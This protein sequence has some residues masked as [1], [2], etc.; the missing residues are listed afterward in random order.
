[1]KKKEKSQQ[2]SNKKQTRGKSSFISVKDVSKSYSL[3][4]IEVKALDKVSLTIKKGEIVSIVGPSGS[5]KTTLLNVIGALDYVDSGSITI[6]GKLLSEM[7]DK[8]WHKVEDVKALMF[9]RIRTNMWNIETVVED[10]VKYYTER[11]V[12]SVLTF[13][14]YYKDE[15]PE[16]Y[17]D[18]Y[19]FRKRT[20]NSYWVIRFDAWKHIM[21]YFES[22]PLVHSC[23]GPD[24][25]ACKNCGT[26]LREFHSTVERLNKEK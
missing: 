18:H 20:L 22:N 8:E 26:C 25:F 3:G 24:N 6:N 9:V 23:S 11:R 15:I 1:M 7:T 16:M 19:E 10:A 17:K 5:G 14:A 21:S 4:E 12:P 13:M 2:S